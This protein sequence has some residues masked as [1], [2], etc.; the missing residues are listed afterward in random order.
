MLQSLPVKNRKFEKYFRMLASQS[1]LDFE[2]VV[3]NW[4]LICKYLEENDGN[5]PT[6]E[7]LMVYSLIEKFIHV[8]CKFDDFS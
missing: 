3:K 1:K 2:G 5:Y 7:I 8:F 4:P 6:K